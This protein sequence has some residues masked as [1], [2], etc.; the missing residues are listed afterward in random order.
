MVPHSKKYFEGYQRRQV[1]ASDGRLR[2]ELV[3]TGV[4]YR[5]ALSSRARKLRRVIYTAL[6]LISILDLLVCGT[7]PIPQLLTWYGVVSVTLLMLI[8]LVTGKF[9]CHYAFDPDELTIYQYHQIK[10]FPVAALAI[11]L[12][13]IPL[14]SVLLYACIVSPSG[15][16]VL[17]LCWT[18]LC[19][20]LLIC[21]WLFER[22]TAY[23]EV[24][25]VSIS[26]QI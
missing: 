10:R 18:V 19:A 3:Y 7:Q 21:V 20:V 23:T 6:F 26:D 8:F 16:L 2:E 1:L 9:F 22:K 12:G 13:L 5:P 24:E 4:Y 17:C 15:S 14:T 11:S 25:A